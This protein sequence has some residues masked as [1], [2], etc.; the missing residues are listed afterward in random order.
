[1]SRIRLS[2][3][4]RA[5]GL[6]ILLLTANVFA[7]WML[8][9]NHL[10]KVVAPQTASIFAAEIGNLRTDLDLVPPEKREEWFRR[11][12][13][14]PDVR[15]ERLPDG[16]PIRDE[17]AVNRYM[18]VFERNLRADA[19]D[20]IRVTTQHDASQYIMKFDFNA[21]GGRY[22]LTIPTIG[23]G[24]LEMW[25]VANVVVCNG[26]IIVIVVLFVLRQINR[27]LRRAAAA[28]GRSAD[29]LAEIDMPGSAPEEFQVFAARFNGLARR[30][31]AQERERSVLLAGVSHDLRA[32]L[33]RI[34]VNAEIIDE[35]DPG[36]AA[37]IL[38][39]SDSMRHIIDQFINH[40][41]GVNPELATR[42]NLRAAVGEVVNSYRDT[43]V[44]IHLVAPGNATV[45]ADPIA[46]ERI[47]SNL[48]GNAIAYGKP[49]FEVQLAVEREVARLIVLD[50]GPGVAESEISRLIKPFERLDDARTAVG[51]CGLGLAIVDR[52]ARQLDG[53][54]A[55]ENLRPNGL[56]A[57]VILP[58]A[59]AADSV[60]V[61]SA[62]CP[63]GG[64]RP[65]AEG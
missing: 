55:I 9:R 53:S 36:K 65:V 59:P 64:I 12:N 51:H 35:D 49:P 11:Y 17:P 46:I 8:Y 32:P 40:Q 4:L 26:I 61:P 39:D 29:Q 34:R 27:P 24:A 22:R 63:E 56:R 62:S 38:R 58:L 33:T 25:S 50:H 15:I 7:T 54:F 2:I 1:M 57:I 48:I 5:A 16:V 52:L 30:L 23:I 43:G 3:V 31:R 10:N 47:L 6:L 21:A 18:E 45:I 13:A 14:R 28:L 42:L 44:D 37:R 60:R 41:R 19:G 20:D